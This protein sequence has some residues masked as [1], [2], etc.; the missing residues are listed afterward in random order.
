MAS[1]PTTAASEPIGSRAEGWRGALTVRFAALI[2]VFALGLAGVLI[3]TSAYGVR[4]SAQ[5]RAERAA[6]VASLAFQNAIARGDAPDAALTTLRG[7][8]GAAYATLQ[9]RP[10]T[11]STEG[12]V[13]AITLDDDVIRLARPVDLPD[14]SKAELRIGVSLAPAGQEVARIVA[15]GMMGTLGFLMLTMPAVVLLFNRTT[16]PLR[17]LARAVTRTGASDADLT[18]AA[19]RADE[20]GA[21]ARAHLAVTRQLLA[22]NDVVRR[23]TFADTLTRLPNR[24]ALRER[25]ATGLQ[26]GE[27]A[28]LLKIGVFG[29]DRVGAG[30]GQSAAD[31]A[32]L[33]V[34]E[35]LRE[36][37]A[38]WARNGPPS[39]A[40]WGDRTATLARTGE[41]EFAI[42]VERAAPDAGDDL[43][44]RAL[45]AFDTP[46]AVDEHQI[47]LGLAIG[48]AFAPA[49]GDE[50][51]E[52]LRSASTALASA[53]AG[54][55]QT[56]R[57]A[58]VAL[59]DD[60]YG[61]LRI[62]QELSRAISNGELE[63]HY[64][65]Q[66]EL[67]GGRV[68]G[69][70]A[71][72][73][74]RHPTRGLVPPDKFVPVAEECGLM[75]SLGRFVIEQ[76]S[77]QAAAW[78]ELG[79]DMRV[80]VNVSALQFRNPRFAEQTLALV[81]GVGCDP[82]LIELEITESVAMSDSLHA[83]REL[84]PLRAAGVRIAIDDFGTGYS[85]LASLT[86]LPFDVL[87]IDRAFVRDAI[88]KRNA[89][90]VVAAVLG[91]AASLGVET[92]A[93][94]VETDDQRALVA[95]HGCTYGQGYLFSP[96][97]PAPAFEAWRQKRLIEE[98]RELSRRAGVSTEEAAARTAT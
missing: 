40:L 12:A 95:S 91:L 36:V 65:P 20:I 98:L 63:L 62:E 8:H 58:G 17:V 90:V 11:P 72:V 57:R 76:A 19:D 48:V 53:R 83:A 92:V 89:Q 27:T 45:A 50:A 64:Q 43:A 46:L 93:E 3:A 5:E 80:A 55:P 96:P 85:N 26:I 41:T 33:G 13:A 74:W 32:V 38:A 51:R 35:R 67:R 97:L 21:L 34:A 7:E 54:G 81:R 86:A 37:L 56:V 61:R 24:E 31:A 87:K 22:T 82:A 6:I 71:L 49:N 73:R 44:Q 18:A 47:T 29:L 30:L 16:R 28:A 2:G 94:G 4:A 77:R 70:E 78:R 88:E 84:A 39:Q 1:E 23:L 42:L 14:G 69:A 75:E 25:I 10:A 68:V 60:A 79:L 9:N 15:A 52:L 59:S 66:I